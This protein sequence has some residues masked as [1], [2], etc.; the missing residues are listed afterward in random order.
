MN[1]SSKIEALSKAIELISDHKMIM[2]CGPN[3]GCKAYIS[4][5]DGQRNN[6]DI[7]D[8]K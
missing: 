1:N 4:R 3:S 8:N 2:K 7:S 5:G 6:L